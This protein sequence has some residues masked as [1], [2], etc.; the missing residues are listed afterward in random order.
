MENVSTTNCFDAIDPSDGKH[1]FQQMQLLR[2]LDALHAAESKAV[3]WLNGP[4]R[5]CQVW[6]PIWNAASLRVCTDG[7]ANS[8]EL[9]V[10]SGEFSLPSVITGDFDSINEHSRS[11]FKSRGVRLQETPDQDFTDMCKALRIIA[12]EIRDRK[13]GINELVILGGLSGRF[14][15]TLSSLHSLLRFKSMSDCVTV[16][17]DSTNLVTIIDR[18]TTELH[19]GGDR[20]LM[21][22]VCG[23]IPFCQ[24]KTTVTTKGFKWDVV[25]AE[26]EFGKLISTSNEIAADVVRIDTSTP[27]IFTMQLTDEAVD[28]SNSSSSS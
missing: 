18:G 19:F 11:Y 6:Q 13:L 7:A 3:L 9:L 26:M 15:H 28:C 12:S 17:I 14:D 16:L 20:S 10:R 24:R 23:F 4:D 25:N 27:L 1:E 8:L 2:P 21:T 5:H 22:S